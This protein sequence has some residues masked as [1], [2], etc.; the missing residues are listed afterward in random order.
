MQTTLLFLLLQTI[1][2]LAPANKAATIPVPQT[3]DTLSFAPLRPM[4]LQEESL[5]Y[6]AYYQW[7]LVWIGAGTIDLR[8]TRDWAQPGA[9]FHATAHAVSSRRIDRFFPVRDRYQT[10]MSADAYLPNRFL[11]EVQE[12]P[13]SFTW[14]YAFD[15]PARAAMA[16]HAG[17]RGTK[18]S[19]LD[20]LPADV[21]DLFSTL[22]RLRAVDWSQV[23]LGGTVPLNLLVDGKIWA[24]SA[25]LSGRE[26]ITIK[27]DSH[28][29]W[30]VQ[31]SLLAG[32]YFKES[33]G[34]RVW[35]TADD[36]C[37]P[38]RAEAAIL[39]GSLKADW[40]P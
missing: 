12:G 24:L 19:Q 31:P 14:E 15:R 8:L 7:G 10:W 35:L 13:V 29:C 17:K 36:R 23:P 34:L 28:D 25:Q 26:T 16:K 40:V 27:G 3:G 32:D 18:T 33:D 1:G 21:G 37:I 22:Y 38:V 11:R 9:P 2:L 30:V 6:R 39:V 20:A 5:T 4:A